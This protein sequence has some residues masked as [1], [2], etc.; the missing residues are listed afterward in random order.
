MRS[1]ATAVIAAAALKQSDRRVGA[2]ASST[3]GLCCVAATSLPTRRRSACA[4]TCCDGGAGSLRRSGSQGQA[5]YVFGGYNGPNAPGVSFL[6]YLS[7]A[8]SRVS[9]EML[10]HV[11]DPM[12]LAPTLALTPA[13]TPSPTSPST[14]TLCSCPVVVEVDVDYQGMLEFIVARRCAVRCVLGLDDA[15]NGLV[16]QCCMAQHTRSIRFNKKTAPPCG[17]LIFEYMRWLSFF[18]RC[19]WMVTAVCCQATTFWRH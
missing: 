14:S 11:D 15:Q 9:N 4:V 10:T 7:G 6:P 1:A 12:T 5:M 8:T 3:R 17:L 13:P 16:A 18:F 2:V 19:R